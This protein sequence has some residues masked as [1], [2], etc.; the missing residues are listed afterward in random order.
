MPLEIIQG[1]FCFAQEH[2][3]LWKDYLFSIFYIKQTIEINEII[4]T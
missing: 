1:H 3:K 4:L 2:H